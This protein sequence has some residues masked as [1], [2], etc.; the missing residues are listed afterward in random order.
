MIKVPYKPRTVV[1][2]KSSE[3]PLGRPKKVELLAD[4]PIT[5]E[6][7]KARANH[8]KK[9][10]LLKTLKKTP[11]SFDVLDQLILDLATEASLLSFDRSEAARCG[12]DSSPTAGK[13][14]TALKTMADLF[15]RKREVLIDQAFDF[16][17]KR[18]EK[19]LEWILVSVVKDSAMESG[20][21]AEQ[22]NILFDNIGKKFDDDRWTQDAMEFIKS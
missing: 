8:V 5:A 7:Q 9:D 14:I 1:F 3:T 16:K 22:I 11:N 21:T 13:R 6:I 10:K 12:K 19:L 15:F 20:L 18:F 2:A 17:S 4:D